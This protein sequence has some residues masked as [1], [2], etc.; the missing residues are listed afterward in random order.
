VARSLDVSESMVKS[1]I[2]E[3]VGGG[4]LAGRFSND[5]RTFITDEAFRRIMK[6]KLKDE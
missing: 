1:I 6:E 4:V 3:A 5:G 2:E